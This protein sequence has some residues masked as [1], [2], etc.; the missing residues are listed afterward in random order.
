MPTTMTPLQKIIIHSNIEIEKDMGSPSFTWQSNTYNFIS[1]VVEFKREL[2]S[3][4]FAIVKMLTATVRLM[5]WDGNA[6]FTT[7]PSPQQK[8]VYNIDGLTYR[9]ESIRKDPTK[10]Y[11]RIVAESQYKGI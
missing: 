4:G 11:F 5:D 10:S 7:L 2:E 3:G 6:I 8:L 9:I 1:S